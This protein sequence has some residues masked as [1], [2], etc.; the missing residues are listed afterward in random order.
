M[1]KHWRR[2]LPGVSVLFAPQIRVREWDYRLQQCLGSCGELGH[3]LQFWKPAIA[4]LPHE[5]VRELIAHELA[6]VLQFSRTRGNLISDHLVPREQDPVEIEADEIME[7]WGF[8]SKALDQ[9]RLL[10]LPDGEICISQP[11]T[12]YLPP[13]LHL[14][15]AARTISEPGVRT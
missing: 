9:F 5:N 4:H 13:P 6:H 14:G 10:E 15:A 2:Q 7:S 11:K 1:F 8:A 12:I 3:E